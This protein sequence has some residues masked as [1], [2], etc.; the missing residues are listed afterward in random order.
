MLCS[1]G[2]TTVSSTVVLCLD[3]GNPRVGVEGVLTCV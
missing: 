2:P 3:F 1:W